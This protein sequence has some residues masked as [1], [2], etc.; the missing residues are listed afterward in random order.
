MHSTTASDHSDRTGDGP[1]ICYDGAG[2][3]VGIPSCN[4][5]VAEFDNGITTILQQSLSSMQPIYFMPT[6]VSDDAKYVKGVSFYILCICGNLINGQKAIVNI[7]GIKSFFDVKVPGNCP[8]PSF[9]TKLAIILFATL[10]SSSK[11][12]FEDICAFPLQGYH[13]E[14][15]AYIHVRTWNHFDRYSTLKAVCEVGIC[16]AS[17]DLNP[18][19]YYR[20]VACEEILPL[21]SWAV[22]LRQKRGFWGKNPNRYSKRPPSIFRSLS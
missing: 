22:L 20:K 4:D 21:S 19:Y 6:E 10:K 7:T 8:L 12:G 11:F 9:K 14:K 13:I 5:I 17:D 16:T 18:T 3:L 15:K 1:L 2:F